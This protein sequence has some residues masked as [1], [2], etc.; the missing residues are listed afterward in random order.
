MPSIKEFCIAYLAWVEAGAPDDTPFSRRHGLCANYNY[1]CRDPYDY[2]DYKAWDEI[3]DL[4]GGDYPFGGKDTFY[5]E[6][7]KNTTHLNPA[8]L[9]WVKE[10][11]Q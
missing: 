8:R 7:D 1:F 4:V 6:V 10:H 2:G 5:E 11:A 3:N 9:A